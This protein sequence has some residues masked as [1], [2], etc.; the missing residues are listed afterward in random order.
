ML[1]RAP[2]KLGPALVMRGNRC[3]CVSDPFQEHVGKLKDT[4]D[5]RLMLKHLPA[6]FN[7]FLDHI[8][9]LDYYTKPDYQVIKSASLGLK[10]HLGTRAAISLRWKPCS[11]Y[12]TSATFY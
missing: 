12:V 1:R 7:V 8:A 10:A 9:N 3:V 5:H 4:Y 2:K 6:E 11:V